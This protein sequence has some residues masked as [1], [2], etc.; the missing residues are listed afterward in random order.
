MVFAP[1]ARS[2][3]IGQKIHPVCVFN[4]PERL[5]PVPFGKAPTTAP[6]D[7]DF[8]SPPQKRHATEEQPHSVSKLP[9]LPRL[10]RAPEPSKNDVREEMLLSVG[11]WYDENARRMHIDDD[12]FEDEEEARKTSDLYDDFTNC[13]NAAEKAA[14]KAS[15]GRELLSLPRQ[16]PLIP[17]LCSPDVALLS[18]DLQFF[19]RTGFECEEDRV[20]EAWYLAGHDAMADMAEFEDRDN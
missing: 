15:I 4:W 13:A 19:T 10:S 11:S 14:A 7:R 17:R 2:D 16:Q 8:S 1:I 20:D 5:E 3:S 12:V 6:Q 9:K 18:T